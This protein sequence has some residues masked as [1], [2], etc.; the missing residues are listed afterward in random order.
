MFEDTESISNGFAYIRQE[1]TVNHSVHIAV[2]HEYDGMY[3]LFRNE[4]LKIKYCTMLT[5]NV[6][7]QSETR[8]L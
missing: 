3:W 6:R 5:P 1:R 7:R 4:N 2:M 8:I